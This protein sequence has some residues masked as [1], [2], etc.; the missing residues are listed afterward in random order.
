[1]WDGE[2]FCGGGGEGVR[3][4]HGEQGGGRCHG[5]EGKW[6]SVRSYALCKSL[7]NSSGQCR[8]VCMTESET[9]IV[10]KVR[11]SHYFFYLFSLIEHLDLFFFVTLLLPVDKSSVSFV[12]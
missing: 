3:E 10:L 4:S 6:F 12:G 1:M 11:R 9:E 7:C 8:S 5:K 2:R